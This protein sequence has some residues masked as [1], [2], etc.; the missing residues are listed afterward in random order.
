M[1]NIH[2]KHKI[3]VRDA[4]T[5]KIAEEG[6]AEN[7]VVN[8]MYDRLL[9]FS[10]FAGNI[11][12]GTGTGTPTVERTTLFNRI[13]S[14]AMTTVELIR[15]YPISVWTMHARLGS[16][17]YNGNNISEV[18]I[19]E[20]TTNINTHAMIKDAEG[21]PLIVPKNSDRIVDFYSTIYA[22]V[23]PVDSGLYWYKNGLRDY[24]TG[25]SAPG[26]NLRIS[27]LNEPAV[28]PGT[29]TY[30]SAAKTV[31]L[32]GRFEEAALNQEVR[33]FDWDGIGL[34]CELPRPGVFEGKQRNNVPIGT[35]DGVK[36]TFLLPQNHIRNIVIKVDNVINSNWTRQNGNTIVFDPIPTTGE[37]TAD[38]LCDLM[39]K[40]LNHAI[41][42]YMEINFGAGEPAAVIPTP[43]VPDLPGSEVLIAGDSVQGFFGEVSAIDLISGDALCAYL[44]LTAG[45]SQNSEAGWLKS[46]LDGR[47]LFTAKKTFRHTISWNDIN[48]VEA[49]F[50]KR[51]IEIDGNVY[52]IK[53]LTSEEWD[54]VIQ[55]VHV[56]G[57][58]PRLYNYSDADLNV[59]SGDGRI[60]WTSTP[61]GSSRI[62]R[63]SGSVSYSYGD[64]PSY[65]NNLYGFRPVLEF[66]YTL[67]S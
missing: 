38:Y 40:D 50:G 66:L 18:G 1:V 21:N 6:F 36:S 22:I 31:K 53:L 19:S 20:T 44:G 35:A 52:A 30:N 13:G 45:I 65:A 43:T 8:R 60:T 41:D 4:K 15:A 10:T 59:N 33:Y 14:K 46:I 67:P 5:M 56:S 55:P 39:P 7:I 3:V 32:A 12:F 17:E 54:K 16:L 49:I 25:G 48:A 37:I 24:L 29:R 42:A 9:T 26:N 47:Y 58:A 61:S 63:G 23:Y 64:S 57:I 27:Y 34:R 51:L 62:S 28:I 11:V 2:N